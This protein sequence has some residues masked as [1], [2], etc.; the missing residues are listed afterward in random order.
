M[1]HRPRQGSEATLR[2]GHEPPAQLRHAAR[3]TAGGTSGRVETAGDEGASMA[4]AGLERSSPG[5]AVQSPAPSPREAAPGARGGVVRRMTDAH[6]ARIGRMITPLPR[7][8]GRDGMRQT[9]NHQSGVKSFLRAAP[10]GGRKP[11]FPP[12]RGTRSHAPRA[13]HGEW[14]LDGEGSLARGRRCRHCRE[15]ARIRP[16]PWPDGWTVACAQSRR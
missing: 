11:L 15:F 2:T 3:A 6:T 8:R 4:N 7:A 5:V 9:A 14:D 12:G 13:T 1:I 16:R 10:S